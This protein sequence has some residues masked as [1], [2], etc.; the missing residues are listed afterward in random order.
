MNA[1]DRTVAA[2]AAHAAAMAD[3]H[4]A[5]LLLTPRQKELLV[6][7]CKGETKKGCAVLLGLSVMTVHH[8][9]KGIFEALEVRTVAEAAVIATKAGLV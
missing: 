4:E 1:N 6:L 8:H 3:A 5:C 9:F 7:V 2:F